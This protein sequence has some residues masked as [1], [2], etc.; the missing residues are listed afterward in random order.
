ML[1]LDP[2]ARL[3]F[4][5]ALPT[6]NPVNSPTDV[7]FACAFVVTDPAKE[8]VA[9]LRL[10]TRVVLDTTNGGVPVATVEINCPETFTVVPV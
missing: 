1:P 6:I 2:F 10:G 7:M 4:A 3:T 9:T 5:V 8:A